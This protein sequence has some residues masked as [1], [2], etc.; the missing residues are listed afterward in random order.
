MFQRVKILTYNSLANWRFIV[1]CWLSLPELCMLLMPVYNPSCWASRRPS[2][3]HCY[4]PVP[5]V[6]SVSISVHLVTF[7]QMQ[8]VVHY[9][10]KHMPPCSLQISLPVIS[11]INPS[12]SLSF[13]SACLMSTDFVTTPLYLMDL[14]FLKAA[15]H[16]VTT[17]MTYFTTCLFHV[18]RSTLVLLFLYLTR[19][20]SL[21][22]HLF[23]L[24]LF[25]HRVL[26]YLSQF[27]ISP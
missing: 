4:V 9:L 24:T 27:E 19:L 6:N 8:T 12:P 13:T 3:H 7:P 16:R 11:H 5:Q 23:H 17:Q 21:V 15:S 25:K 10:T 1:S 26:V 2:G 22:T 18:P 20:V 14:A